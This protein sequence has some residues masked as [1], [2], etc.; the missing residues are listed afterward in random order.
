MLLVLVCLP[1]CFSDN[2]LGDRPQPEPD[3]TVGGRQIHFGLAADDTD[4]VQSATRATVVSLKDIDRAGLYGYYTSD[5]RWEW[6]ADNNPSTLKPNYFSNEVLYKEGEEGAYTWSYAG[7]PR[8][9][10]PDTRYK[11][12]FFAYSPYIQTIGTNGTQI[13]L[14]GRDIIPAPAT[15]AQT[16]LPTLTYTVP[17]NIGAHF[18][19]MR[20]A[21]ID[22][23]ENGADGIAGT[24]DDGKALITMEHALTQITFTL[25]YA[26]PE[27]DTKYWFRLDGID[28]SGLYNKGTLRLDDGSWSFDPSAE[29]KILS[30]AD[31]NLSPESRTIDD[32]ET[33]Y[34]LLDPS[35]GTLMLIP[36]SLSNVNLTLMV[37]ITDTNP[38]KSPIDVPISFALIDTGVEWVPGRSIDYRILIE[39]GFISIHTTITRWANGGSSNIVVGL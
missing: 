33:I 30:I 14:T 37:H 27:D 11:V 21:C 8:F 35:I 28:L 39:A 4:E 32:G 22:M 24:T 29:R 17:A 36:Q 19:L 16:G 20:G 7:L 10:P 5:E 13:D 25:Q 1:G 2:T 34:P 38:L 18:D 6:S 12:S 23:T 31:A 15:P 9:W 26:Y 3:P